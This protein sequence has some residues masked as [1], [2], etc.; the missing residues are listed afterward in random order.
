MLYSIRSI[1]LGVAPA[2]DVGVECG[3]VME[4]MVNKNKPS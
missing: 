1:C 3:I 4:F 2:F